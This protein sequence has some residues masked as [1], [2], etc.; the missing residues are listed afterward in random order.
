[1][2]TVVYKWLRE[3]GSPYYVGIGN[4]KRPYTGRRLC[5]FPPPDDR[6][7][8]L[9]KGLDWKTACEIERELISFYGRKDLKTGI[10]CNLTDGGEGVPGYKHTEDAKK[11]MSEVQTGKKLSEDHKEK[12]SKSGS[13]ENHY[14]YGKE[15]TK[16]TKR[17]ISE[18]KSGKK[19]H[20][21]GQKHTED[22]IKKMSETRKSMGISGKNHPFYGKKHT[23]DARK[24]ISD[25]HLGENNYQYA[26]KNWYHPAYGK[27]LGKS[28]PELI[29]MFPEQKLDKSALNRVANGL[30]SHHKGWKFY[31]E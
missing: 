12:I 5:G 25:S 18:A 4:P 3:D 26:P 13:G 28:S 24:K 21:Y 15:H 23:D 9:Y 30:A 29:R 6:I 22:T 19:H 17:K 14:F 2:D 10:L 1:M 31:Q 8:I 27:V 20:F 7:I 11:K 16:E